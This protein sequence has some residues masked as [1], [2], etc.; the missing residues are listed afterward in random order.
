MKIVQQRV[1]HLP[2]FAGSGGLVLSILA[3]GCGANGANA[4]RTDDASTGSAPDA[5]C[6][7]E[8]LFSLD[9]MTRIG[10]VSDIL[11]RIS[12]TY[13]GTL[14]W[15]APTRDDVTVQP[16]PGITSLRME[17]SSG[18]AS[19]IL[20]DFSCQHS[21]THPPPTIFFDV[22]V[23]FVTGDGG[24]D[25]DWRVTLQMGVPATSDFRTVASTTFNLSV[26][27][28]RERPRGTFRVAYVGPETW[29]EISTPLSGELNA[30]GAHGEM[31]YEASR[32]EPAPPHEARISSLVGGTIAQW[33]AT[34]TGRVDEGGALD[35]VSQDSGE[36][37]ARDASEGAPEAAFEPPPDGTFDAIDGDAS[38]E[39]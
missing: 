34:K 38:E 7:Q 30:G 33:E 4:Q 24:F 2:C 5:S 3:A 22:D 25:E 10:K 1:L 32:S 6:P 19:A 15:I 17:V 12:G 39:M 29:D 16:P 14:T 35:I 26:D 13:A 27:P 11:A 36:G 28:T 21:G 20:R 18:A 37:S 23:R 8:T 9:D 31:T